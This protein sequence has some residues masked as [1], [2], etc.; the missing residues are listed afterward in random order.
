[1][2]LT[3]GEDSVTLSADRRTLTFHGSTSTAQDTVPIITAA[4]PLATGV[5]APASLTMLGLG[6]LGLL[7]YGWR[8]R[9]AA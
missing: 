2:E 1:M 8:K 7:G 4:S 5:P 9:K 3:P 6:A